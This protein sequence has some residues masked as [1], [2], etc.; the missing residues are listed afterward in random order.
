MCKSES[1]NMYLAKLRAIGF[2]Q[3]QA[4]RDGSFRYVIEHSGEYVVKDGNYIST[5]ANVNIVQVVRPVF[6]H[7]EILQRLCPV[8]N[9]MEKGL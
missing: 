2:A 8:D 1:E 7:R 6:C 9:Q 4:N 5:T 3:G